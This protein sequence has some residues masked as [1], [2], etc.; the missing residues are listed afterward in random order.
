MLPEHACSYL[1]QLCMEM[2]VPSKELWLKASVAW[3][4]REIYFAASPTDTS[5]VRVAEQ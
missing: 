1:W 3:L 4:L 5:L 2:K